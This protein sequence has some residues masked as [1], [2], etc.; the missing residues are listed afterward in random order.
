MKLGS[1]AAS[2][3]PRPAGADGPVG[4]R[5]GREEDDEEDEFAEGGDKEQRVMKALVGAASCGAGAPAALDGAPAARARRAEEE[6]DEVRDEFAEE[7]A[8][9]N[10]A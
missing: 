8:T 9:A 1:A 4:E 6:D 5:A 2:R 3:A 7:G 10:S